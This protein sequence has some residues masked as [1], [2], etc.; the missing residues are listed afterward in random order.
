MTLELLAVN[1]K[2]VLAFNFNK[3]ARKRGVKVKKK[4]LEEFLQVPIVE[5]EANTGQGQ[6]E[7]LDQVVATSEREYH[8][9]SFLPELM[10]NEQEISHV[11]AIDFLRKNI[12]NNFFQSTPHGFSKKLD[13][14]ALSRIWGFPFLL[15]VVYLMFKFTFVLS[16]PLIAVAEQAFSTLA[17]WVALLPFPPFLISMLKDGLIGGIGSVVVFVPLIFFLF[18]AIAF[19]EDSGYLSRAVVLTDRIFQRFGVT[20]RSL[21]PMILGFGC[22][23]PAVMAGRTIRQK[24]ERKIAIFVNPFISCSARLPVYLMV[25]HIFFPAR[26]TLVVF[27]LYVTGVLIAFL[28]SFVYSKL[29]GAGE[30]SGM[31]IELPP[32][33][34]P[35]FKNVL[36][37]GWNNTYLFLKKAGTLI[38]LASLAVWLL[39]SLPIGVEYG[40]A[41]SWLGIIGK[42]ISFIFDPLGFGHWAFAVALLFGVAAKETII[43]TLGALF[44]V[45]E[46]GLALALPAK[47]APAGALAFLFF[48]LLYIPCLATMATVKKETGSWKFVL[49]QALTTFAVAWVVAYAVNQAAGVIIG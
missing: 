48:V 27:S 41:S 18:I 3:E 20:G 7:L 31:I 4:E 40:G 33:R 6:K 49:G 14:V 46:S 28:I 29:S 44:G 35:N 22:N 11:Q 39:A 21:I 24:K 15:L 10:K 37:S 12:S 34:R 13:T 25:A 30:E 42:Q 19:L 8:R 9:P 5:I 36:R 26:A 2:V 32:Y 17:S 23:V 1:I 45:G 47:I 43:S 16:S 38:L